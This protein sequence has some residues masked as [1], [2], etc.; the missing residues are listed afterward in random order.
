MQERYGKDG[1]KI[2]AI[3]L[4]ESSENAERF[5]KKFPA[6]FDIAYDPKGKT[7]DAYS[8]SVMPSSFLLNEKG[9]VIYKHRG[10]DDADKKILEN[11]I[12]KLVGYQEVA[13]R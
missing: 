5:L 12:R 3:N 4:D 9:Q 7:A 6:Q 8:L 1:F 10:F 13:N 2:V 11:K